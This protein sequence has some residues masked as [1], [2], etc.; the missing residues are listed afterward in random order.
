LAE[1]FSRKISQDLEERGMLA[2]GRQAESVELSIAID[3]QRHFS[4]E[5][6]PFPSNSVVRPIVGYTITASRDG[7]VLDVIKRSGLTTSHGFLGNLKTVATMGLGND[8]ASEEVDVR[9]IAS[10]M[11]DFLVR[12]SG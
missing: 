2:F 1:M 7:S 3:Y 5:D 9:I 11:V 8:A 6:T 10:G 4:G 12:I